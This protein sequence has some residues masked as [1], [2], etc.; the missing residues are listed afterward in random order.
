MSMSKRNREPKTVKVYV[1]Q[2]NYGQGWEDVGGS[3]NLREAL[4]DLKAYRENAP[5]YR[6]R[7]IV[8]REPNPRYVPPKLWDEDDLIAD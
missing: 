8:R 3:E 6:Y 4:D 2:G 1:V 7:W 5:E